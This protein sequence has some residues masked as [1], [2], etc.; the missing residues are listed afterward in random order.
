MD[1]LSVIKITNSIRPITLIFICC[2]LSALY[3]CSTSVEKQPTKPSKTMPTEP[4][5][6]ST[7]ELE[8]TAQ[9]LLN[10][11]SGENNQQAITYLL[12]ASAK[13]IE[14][15]QVNNSLHISVQLA[16]L[17]LNRGQA[18]LNWLNMSEALFLLEQA[19]LAANKLA[20]IKTMNPSARQ[21]FLQAQVKVAQGLL[22][23]GIVSYLNYYQQY[24]LNEKQQAIDLQ[25]LFAKLTP[26]QQKALA[27]RQAYQLKGWL[28][29][30][31]V[32][33]RYTEQPEELT[34][35][36]NQW[37]SSHPQ[38]PAN[39]LI[40]DLTNQQQNNIELTAK[41]IVV[42]I[43]LSGREENLGKT[44][45]AGIFSAY[46]QQSKQNSTS[47]QIR[48]IDTNS[49][50]MQDIVAELHLMSPDFVIGPLLKQHVES[51]L[52]TNKP[53]HTPLEIPV[54][55][56]LATTFE[57]SMESSLA[58]SLERSVDNSLAGADQAPRENQPV[59]NNVQPQKLI[60]S[61]QDTVTQAHTWINLLLNL[62]EQ[63]MLTNQQFALSMLPEDE[64]TQAAFSLS[65]KPYINALVLSQNTVIGKR[66]A[67][68][69]A[70]QWQRQT[71]TVANIIYYP[72]GKK[73]QNAVKKSLDV[74]LSDERIRYIR[75]RIK[76]NVKSEAR[77]RRDI[78]MIYMFATP[79]QA[80][81][82]K[83]YID[84]NISPFADA[85]PIYASSRSHN[86]GSNK[87]THRDLTGLT[88]TEI[89]WLLNGK[90]VNPDL[91]IQARQVWPNR[92]SQLERIF[93]MGID[94]WQLVD[95]VLLMQRV[96]LIR[97]QGETGVLQMDE[98]GII[99]RSLS[100]GRYHSSKVQSVAMD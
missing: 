40:E 24:P 59:N 62:P 50:P 92:S 28:S 33:S 1:S 84:V 96:P 93:A 88:F 97:H 58:T 18:N 67:Q 69:F 7:P 82:L 95:K 55:N 91:A 56:S 66:M 39:I 99:S 29:Y 47:P 87:N 77:S 11:A 12:Q 3:G 48:F 15:Q 79:D 36:L 16:K 27:K 23:D 74:D 9:A 65:Q 98:N 46:I 34:T 54:A 83:P 43:P 6:I 45:Q 32:V 61:E 2:T 5:L 42:L 41:S 14:Q 21:L 13:Y 35:S 76:E 51:Y 94:S 73:M 53:I 63:S 20:N 30:V 57:P 80:R 75:N 64:A 90:Q 89:P 68:R 81:L 26:W 4:P 86:I 10:K 70:E 72:V 22:V 49:K 38:H 52:E 19:D 17:D 37:R 44:L 85:I 71:D 100:W 25:L 31:A 78:D 60:S 8:V